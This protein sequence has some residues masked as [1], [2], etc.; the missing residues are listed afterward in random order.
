MKI[1]FSQL[2]I[3]GTL[4]I[5]FAGLML[6]VLSKDSNIE[7]KYREVVNVFDIAKELQLDEQKFKQDIDS[8]TIHNRVADMEEDV[9]N[10]LNGAASTPAVFVNGAAY[11]LREF[12]A[13]KD[14]LELVKTES[15]TNPEV[16]FPVDMEVFIDYNCTHCATF[17][18]VVEQMQ[19]ELSEYATVSVKHLPFLKASSDTYAYA[20]EA[21]R[22]QGKFNEFNSALFKKIHGN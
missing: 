21:A 9:T 14:D 12:E 6:L 10:R 20:A 18:L 4:V 7:S 1:S 22:E 13:I 8:E 5:G 15:E 11:N 3:I 16:K 17:E 2:A 19:A